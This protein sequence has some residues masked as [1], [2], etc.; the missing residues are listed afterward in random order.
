MKPLK[1]PI[2][3]HITRV[4]DRLGVEAY[5]V[6]GFVRDYYLHRPS[7]DIDVVVVGNGVAVAE[8]LAKELGVRVTI[9]RTYGTAMLHWNDVEVEFVGARRES[10]SPNSRNPQVEL[11]LWVS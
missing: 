6:G 9:Y 3:K 2:F 10:Y 1:H 5:A 8:E 11:Y 4:V 7:S